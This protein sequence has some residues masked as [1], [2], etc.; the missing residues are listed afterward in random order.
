MV[1][2]MSSVSTL[3]IA[4][5]QEAVRSIANNESIFIDAKSFN[6]TPGKSKDDVAV[7][8][9]NLGAR[10]MGP[11]AIIFRSADKLYIVDVVVPAEK[12]AQQ[13]M[14]DPAIAR[15]QPQ[16]VRDSDYAPQQLQGLRDNDYARQQPQ[17]L[18]DNDYA[19]QQPQGLRDTDGY[20]RQQPQG[21]R[22]N[23]YARQQPQ[24]LRDSDVARQQPQ[25]LR[26]TDPA[27]ERQRAYMMDPDYVHYRLKKTFQEVWSTG[28]KS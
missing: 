22:D 18:R 2:M 21:L 8:I 7:Q 12:N 24:G 10:E 28:N 26:D 4:Q 27:I 6:V 11:G 16:G 19:R 1:V 17:G 3:A 13:A 9:K 25:G 5:S 20:A 23:D 15:Q 14:Y